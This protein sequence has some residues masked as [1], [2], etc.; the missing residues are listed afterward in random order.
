MRSPSTGCS[1]IWRIVLGERARLVQHRLAGADLADVVQ[2][3]ADPDAVEARSVE[4][5]RS[6]VPTAYW[7]TRMEC[8]RV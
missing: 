7:L 1:V 3:G 4:A 6:A 2:L 5:E 8:P